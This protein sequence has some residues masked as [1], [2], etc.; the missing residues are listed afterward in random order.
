MFEFIR[1]PFGLRNSAQTFQRLI[2]EV[3]S[4]YPFV[5]TYIDDVLI[6]STTEK[7]HIQHIH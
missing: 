5:F 3:F 7:E 4:E 2:N 6:S 1:T